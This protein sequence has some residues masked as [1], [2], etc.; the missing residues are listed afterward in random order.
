VE[1]S[2]ALEL[3]SEYGSLYVG[4]AGVGGGGPGRSAEVKGCRGL[5]P[6]EGEESSSV[7]VSEPEIGSSSQESAR[8]SVL[9]LILGCWVVE[10]LS[11]LSDEATSMME[12]QSRMLLH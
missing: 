3:S 1:A 7:S 11:D 6:E 4:E 5:V 8:L 9:T 2:V 10:S 12:C